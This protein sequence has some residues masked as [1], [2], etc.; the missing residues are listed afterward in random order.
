MRVGTRAV[1]DT[2]GI[3]DLVTAAQFRSIT[4]KAVRAGVKVLLPVA[5]A[6]APRRP[7][8][9]A[10]K[11]SQGTK[12]VKG[13]KGRTGSYA[14]QG[15]KAKTQKIVKGKIVK[16]G[17]YDHLVQGGTKPHMVG[18][19]KHPGARPNPYRKRAYET[20]KGT[21]GDVMTGVMAVEVQ[22]EIAKNSARLLGK[23][24]GK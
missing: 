18:K 11:Q 9:G 17:K 14:V 10:L 3:R 16:P 7:G 15:A 4:L 22:K 20:V 5:K 2:S 1:V 12:A 24:T 8:S 21:I 13:R 19:K 6:G 23:I